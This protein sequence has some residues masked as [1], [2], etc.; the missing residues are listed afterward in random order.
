MLKVNNKDTRTT[1]L[2]QKTNVLVRLKPHTI[3]IASNAKELEREEEE[4]MKKEEFYI[5]QRYLHLK[6]KMYNLKSC[7]SRK[8]QLS[9]K[10][11]FA[12]CVENL[13]QES[14]DIFR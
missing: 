1:P 4:S 9:V 11:N 14:D 5:K 2:G 7:Y 3:W 6:T 10:L 12:S 8:Y 13:N